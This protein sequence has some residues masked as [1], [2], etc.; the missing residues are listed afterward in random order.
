VPSIS[1]ALVPV[2]LPDNRR[3][4]TAIAHRCRKIVTRRAMVSASAAVVPIPGVD[5]LVDLAVL[6]K[7]LHEINAEFGLTPAQIE[8]LAPKRRLTAYKA[9]NALGASTVGRLITRELLFTLLKSMAQR[10]A[11]KTSAKYVPIAGQALAA[12]LSFAVIK[13]I[14]DRHVAACAAVADRVIDIGSGAA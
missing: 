13:V 12:G 5:I 10:V 4:L 7:M 6:T 1:R 8:L 2:L 11:T 9:I 14:G 3:D